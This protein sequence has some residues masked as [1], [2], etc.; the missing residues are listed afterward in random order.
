MRGVIIKRMTSNLPVSNC[1]ISKLNHSP[2][3]KR[4]LSSMACIPAPQDPHKCGRVKATSNNSSRGL[5][6]TQTAPL[7][8]WHIRIKVHH[9]QAL[10]LLSHMV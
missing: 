1:Q 7:R 6:G 8:L 2:Q 10:M 5:K 3:I 9:W 4:T